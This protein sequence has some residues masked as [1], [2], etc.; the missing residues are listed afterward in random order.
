MKP[1]SDLCPKCGSRGVYEEKYLGVEE[2]SCWNCGWAGGEIPVMAEVKGDSVKCNECEYVSRNTA[3]YKNH[4][5]YAHG[6]KRVESRG[7]ETS[8]SPRT[9][10]WS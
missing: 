8:I 9:A 2:V 5:S 7:A 3:G 4:Y 10:W 6:G 1:K